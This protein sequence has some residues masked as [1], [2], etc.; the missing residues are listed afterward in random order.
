MPVARRLGRHVHL[1]APPPSPAPCAD[2]AAAT[3]TISQAKVVLGDPQDCTDSAD[4]LCLTNAIH[5]AL[6]RRGQA[7]GEY[8]PALATSW[9]V[10]ADC[11]TWTVRP[12]SPR[13]P[14]TPPP[15]RA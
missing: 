12:P 15:S 8:L 3:L 1:G 6:V 14:S 2:A 5:D 11:R 7:S 4:T 13:P 9:A 10:S